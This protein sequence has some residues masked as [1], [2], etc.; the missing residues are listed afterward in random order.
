MI[1][2]TCVFCGSLALLFWKKIRFFLSFLIL[3]LVS[4]LFPL[5]SMACLW[6]AVDCCSVSFHLLLDL[7]RDV[8]L[9]G[10]VA[11]CQDDMLH[12]VYLS[13]QVSPVFLSAE[14]AV[15]PSMCSAAERQMFPTRAAARIHA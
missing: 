2:E 1:R 9:S 6:A 11:S 5:I 15:P 13:E 3:H 8:D 14:S 4:H 12:P 7:S 10:G